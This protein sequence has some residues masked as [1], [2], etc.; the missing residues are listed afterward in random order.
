MLENALQLL[1]AGLIAVETRTDSDTD[2][3]KSPNSDMKWAP[4]PAGSLPGPWPR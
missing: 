1:D 4:L 3:F 2:L